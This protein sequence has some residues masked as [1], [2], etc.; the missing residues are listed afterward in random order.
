M[1]SIAIA[2]IQPVLKVRLQGR[3]LG[4]FFFRGMDRGRGR[5]EAATLR[6]S[7][8]VSTFPSTFLTWAWACARGLSL[9]TLSTLSAGHS[10]TYT[11]RHNPT[12]TNKRQA[13]PMPTLL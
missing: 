7:N 13:P 10:H 6:G 9:A 5:H 1:R 11:V 2:T 4:V 12:L 3:V 8:D